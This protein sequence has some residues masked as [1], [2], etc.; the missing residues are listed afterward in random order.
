M[1]RCVACSDRHRSVSAYL[2][3]LCC[4]RA[5]P[6][7]SFVTGNVDGDDDYE[8]SA[9]LVRKSRTQS[10][11]SGECPAVETLRV[12]TVGNVVLDAEKSG[13]VSS[14]EETRVIKP[15]KNYIV[16]FTSYKLQKEHRK[17]LE[18]N[19]PNWFLRHF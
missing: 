7:K 12:D 14:G 3:R 17:T 6:S 1:E 16:R 13:A 15:T 10:L 8:A 11:D 4:T 19:T 5:S 9:C 2:F 18:P